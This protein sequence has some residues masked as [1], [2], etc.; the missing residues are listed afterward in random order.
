MRTQHRLC[1]AFTTFALLSGCS[2]TEPT[3]GNPP[4]PQPPADAPSK[5]DAH[6]ETEIPI[7]AVPAALQ[8]TTATGFLRDYSRLKP[9]PL[10]KH[11]LTEFSDKLGSYKAFIIDPPKVI[12]TTTVRG[13][14]I[15]PASAAQLAA[16]LTA[17]TSE[18]VGV[19]FKITDKP[20]ED[21]ARIRLAITQIAEGLHDPDSAHGKIGGASVEMEI[22]DAVTGERLAA[23]TESDA[24]TTRDPDFKSDAPYYDARL[25]F[26]HWAARLAKALT[27][28]Q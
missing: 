19:N 12:P 7:A 8:R 15:D 5:A 24:V 3:P 27:D 26:Q 17:A 20:G 1:L 16:D 11:S 2:T 14:P 23:A 22:T 21:V 25:V 13:V 10:H 28:A 9:N 18:A 6:A 4:A